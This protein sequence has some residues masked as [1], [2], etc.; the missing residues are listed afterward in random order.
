MPGVCDDRS[1]R[2]GLV[3]VSTKPYA[4]SHRYAFC[5]RAVFKCIVRY[6]D[7]EPVSPEA[8]LHLHAA[9]G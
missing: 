6:S 8:H 3:K 1:G 7:F 2:N 4:M 9:V 5:F